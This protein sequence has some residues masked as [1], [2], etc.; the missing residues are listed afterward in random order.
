M[1]FYIRPPGIYKSTCEIPA[2]LLADGKYLLAIP[3]FE[4]FYEFGIVEKDVIRFT[5]MSRVL[6]EVIC[7]IPKQDILSSHCLNGNLSEKNR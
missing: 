3:L 4:G 2:N 6:F 1:Y 5:R 7:L